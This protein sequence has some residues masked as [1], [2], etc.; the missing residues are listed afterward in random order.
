MTI[1][2]EGEYN[3][4]ATENPSEL[5]TFDRYGP[6]PCPRRGVEYIFVV[7]DSFSKLVC[8]YALKKSGQMSGGMLRRKKGLRLF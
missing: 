5:V 1:A 3:F 2:I 7:L 8:M 4:V 6:L